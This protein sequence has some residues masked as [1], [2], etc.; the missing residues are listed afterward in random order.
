M[1]PESLIAFLVKQELGEQV[2]MQEV[3]SDFEASGQEVLEFLAASGFGE[4]EEILR[5][6]AD[7]QGRQF[8]DLES[9][10]MPAH[11]ISAIDPDIRRIFGCLPLEVSND[12][13]KVCLVDPF[14]DV[15]VKE[16]AAILGKKV[17][18][19]IADPEKIN[20]R[21]AAIAEGRFDAPQEVL[22]CASPRA[23]ASKAQ[24]K[25][26][27]KTPLFSLS[28]FVV[29][30][31]LAVLVTASAALYLSQNRRLANWQ[32]L[33]EENE[34]LTRQSDASRKGFE[35]TVFQMENELDA[36][37]KLITAKE[38]DAIKIDALE[39]ELRGLRGKIDSLG[40][41]L[42][43]AGEPQVGDSDP[44]VEKSDSP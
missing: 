40:K 10:V 44:P 3:V 34:V 27:G 23:G 28:F 16:L 12:A 15:A 31:V 38:V 30:G 9:V 24:S 25:D 2:S 19:A 32:A 7:E 21:L 11:L 42:A 43:K 36:L 33:V 17:E 29:L 37:E 14:D 26:A 1:D 22:A 5:L 39:K 4:R 8:I 18:V 35:A 20:S 6:V 13:A 41:I